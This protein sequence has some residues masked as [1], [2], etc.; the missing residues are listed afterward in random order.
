MQSDHEGSDRIHVRG[1]I[2]SAWPASKFQPAPP[3]SGL[4]H[5]RVGKKPA[6]PY[7]FSTWKIRSPSPK[8]L[9]PQ[10][11]NSVASLVEN[12]LSNDHRNDLGIYQ[13][14]KWDRMFAHACD[15]RKH[16]LLHTG[17]KPHKC[18]NCEKAFARRYVLNYHITSRYKSMWCESIMLRKD[19]LEM[20]EG[21]W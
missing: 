13:C 20:P 14:A 8:N 19:M 2:D 18:P 9:R 1:V 12:L 4:P 7:E 17:G 11:G 6:P 5:R 21:V 15:L 10:D 16:L 3:P